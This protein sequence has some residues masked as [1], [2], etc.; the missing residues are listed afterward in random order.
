MSKSVRQQVMEIRRLS[1]SG[2][3]SDWGALCEKAG[4][5]VLEHADLFAAAEE[6]AAERDQLKV[7]VARLRG[8][9]EEASKLLDGAIPSR[10]WEMIVDDAIEMLDAALH[11]GD[12]A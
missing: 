10:D 3:A 1:R 4:S 6:T 8:V 11:L 9:I 5:L 7:E 12:D 2:W